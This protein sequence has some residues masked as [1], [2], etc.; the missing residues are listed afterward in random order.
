MESWIVSETVQLM[1]E[2]AGLCSRAPALEM[3][4][5]A[6]VTP[7]LNAQRNSWYH[8]CRLFLSSTF[9]RALATRFWCGPCSGQTQSPFLVL[10]QYLLSQIS[11][12]VS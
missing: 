4:L 3:I 11:R 10:R 12:E 2:V 1:V 7:C 9:A 8:S 5:P 6:G